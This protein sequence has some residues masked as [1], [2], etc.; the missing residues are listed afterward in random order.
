MRR[1]LKLRC[2]R[3][4]ETLQSRVLPTSRNGTEMLCSVRWNVMNDS[5]I[6]SWDDVNSITT[7]KYM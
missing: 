2:D 3:S 7:Y 4:M 6:P 1:L 5:T